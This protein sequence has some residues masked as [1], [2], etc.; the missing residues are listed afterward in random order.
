MS[1]AFFWLL[2]FIVL[3]QLHLMF[4]QLD[5]LIDGFVARRTK[6]FRGLVECFNKSK[7]C[8]I[9]EWLR[10]CIVLHEVKDK[11]MVKVAVNLFHICKIKS[12][13]QLSELKDYINYF[14]FICAI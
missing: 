4:N 13:M 8:L 3:I 14:R 10:S 1:F 11:H 2:S 12:V 5:H 9:Q 7:N 6:V